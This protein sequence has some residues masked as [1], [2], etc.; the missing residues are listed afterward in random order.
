MAEYSFDDTY[1]LPV[2]EPLAMQ[3]KNVSV[4]YGKQETPSLHQV[5]MDFAE[6]KITALIGPS[7]SGKSTYLRCLNRMNDE[8]GR[9]DGEILYRGINL[10]SPQVNVYETRREI[11]MVFQHPNPFAKSIREN[12]TFSP[13]LYGIK[14]QQKLDQMVE[15]SLKSVA[16]WDEVKDSL[17]R[18][19][20]SLSGGQQQRLCIARSLAMDPKIILMDEPASALDPIS[21]SKLEE[22]MQTLKKDHTIII[23]THNMQQAARCSDYCAFFYLGH[24]LE[25][26]STKDI[27]SNPKI[28]ATNDYVSGNFG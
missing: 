11:G 23:V 5:S 21:T 28:K 7:G 3:T 13:K 8:L 12:I 17:D 27:F 20:L 16:L 14:D 1:T 22:T 9:I 6:N 10:N 26:N 15:E 4:Y 19:A 18:G 25:F 2:K 24:V